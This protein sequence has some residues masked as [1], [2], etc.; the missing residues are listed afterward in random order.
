M[1]RA[2]TVRPSRPPLSLALCSFRRHLAALDDNNCPSA[3]DLSG[4]EQ[5]Y[6]ATFLSDAAARLDAAAPGAHLTPTDALNFMQICG[7]ES[8]YTQRLSPWCKL[9]SRQEFVA[10]E[11]SFPSLT[12]TARSATDSLRALLAVLLR[13]GQVLRERPR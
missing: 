3:P 4:F 11:V 9:F 6:L 7:F 8:Q 12:F 5:S 13:L 1:R 10:G 2:T